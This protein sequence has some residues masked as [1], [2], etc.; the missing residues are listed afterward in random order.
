[1]TSSTRVTAARRGP[2][3][4]VRTPAWVDRHLGVVLTGLV[5]FV[6][7]VVVV[8]FH[9]WPAQAAAGATAPYTDA[10]ATGYVTLYDKAGKAIKSG[11]VKD[12]PFVW[13]AVGTKPAAAPYD[14]QGHKATLMAYQPRKGVAAGAWSSDTLTASTVYSDTKH[15]TAQATA[16]DFSLQDFLAEFPPQW[17][18]MVQVR[19]YLSAPKAQPQTTGYASTDLKITGD[20]WVVV[21]GGPGAGPGGV[22]IPGKVA[23]TATAS[24]SPGGSAAPGASSGASAGSSA[25]AAGS[26]DGTDTEALADLPYLRTPGYLSVAAA[27]IVA[28]VFAGVL[29]RR[30]RQFAPGEW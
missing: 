19:L 3:A 18:G 5:A 1:M 15:P 9:V 20:T 16:E 7:A 17:D 28:V 25:G 14:G 13:K 21:G 2:A 11:S 12:K 27:V 22:N 4:P 30:R 29:M 24:A 8:S 6:V 26:G 23:S 10:Q